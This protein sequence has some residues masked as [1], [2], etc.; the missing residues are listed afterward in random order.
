VRLIGQK[1]T[2]LH[3]CL[4]VLPFLGHARRYRL[5]SQQ[6]EQFMHALLYR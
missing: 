6:S 4:P 5:Q 1:K 2:G 3:E